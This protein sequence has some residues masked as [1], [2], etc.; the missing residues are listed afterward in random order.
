MKSKVF[1]VPIKDIYHVNLTFPMEDF[2]AFYQSSPQGS[3]AQLVGYKGPNG[4]FAHLRQLGYAHHL[5]ASWRSLAKGF[6]FF[7]VTVQM[8]ESG[9]RHVDEIV[10]YVFQYIQLIKGKKIVM[11]HQ[12]PT[13]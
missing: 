10:K 7:M 9:E 2:S 3:V 5:I 11:T 1:I 8:T 4:L 13:E 6:S 12:A